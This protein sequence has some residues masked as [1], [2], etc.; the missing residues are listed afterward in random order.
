MRTLISLCLFLI[1]CL[2]CAQNT[3]INYQ[4]SNSDF[5]NP[6]RGFYRYSVTSSTSYT[7]LDATTLASY[8]SLHTPPT[9]N[10]QIYSTLVFR[11]FLL[12]N[13]K[14]AP[15]SQSYLDNMQADFDAART[16]GVKLIPR[17]AYTQTP[18]KCGDSICP[19]HGDAP[20]NW[21]LTHIDQIESVLK[22]N[23][24]VLA[25]LQMGFIGVWGENYYTDYFGDASQ[26][27]DFKLTD[28]NWADR[29]EVMNALL[30]AVPE[31]RMVQA[32][33]PQMKQRSVYGINAPTSSAALLES[34][35][36]TGS[37]KARIGLH[38]D[39]LLASTT[40][41]GTYTNYGNSSTSSGDDV[42]N[43]KPYFAADGQFVVVGGET[44]SDGFSPQN[45]CASSNVMAFGDT[46]LE[47]L[48]YSYL[49]SQYNN[50]VNNDWVSDGC[51]DDI[52]RRLGYRFELQNGIYSNAAQP[53]QIISVDIDLK[54]VGYASPFNERAVEL[55][56]RNT[57]TDELW[58]ALLPDDPRFWFAE[59]AV[60]T[61]AHNLCIPS[62]MPTG[63]Y[64]LLLNLPDPM[65]LLAKRPE[66]AIRI[67]NLLP[68]NSDVWE[69]S[70]G[71][72]KLGHILAINNSAS[73]T[74]C[75]GEIRFSKIS[76]VSDVV[77]IQGKVFLQGA[78]DGTDMRTNLKTAD[79]LPM[80]DP[81]NMNESVNRLPDEVVDWI[82]VELRDKDNSSNVLASR[83]CFLRNDGQI[84]EL[85]GT[86]DITFKGVKAEEAFVS[87][88]HRNHLGVMTN[89]PVSLN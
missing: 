72:N 27:P 15:I 23:K 39:C 56:L 1:P 75:N 63:S 41:F 17:F 21:V 85:D 86:L 70:T 43:L 76:Q 33:Y 28:T 31:E 19:P 42:A 40:D 68:D 44:C 65:P 8:R 59:N 37:D 35:A 7:V 79:V 10:Y 61:I 53:N 13:F 32:R 18:N 52:K 55:V 48:H 62:D 87:V 88:K 51:M 60:N 5:A 89:L 12:E 3:T 22:K 14:N 82:V 80:G 78:Y 26:G 38:N 4:S 83:A 84:M 49:N 29:I 67:A 11:Y 81:F 46:E 54:N 16:S 34:E 71:F 2:F 57:S 64:E 24:D 25:C 20:K 77:Q 9:A 45:D 69:A 73:N 30:A 66:Y 50:E 58:Y 74:T 6:E 36:F 47:D